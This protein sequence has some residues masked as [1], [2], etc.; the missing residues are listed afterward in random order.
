MA[1]KQEKPDPASQMEKHVRVTAKVND[2]DV[3]CFEACVPNGF[4]GEFRK[5]MKVFMAPD[6]VEIHVDKVKDAPKAGDQQQQADQPKADQS[7]KDDPLGE[8]LTRQEREGTK[9]APP[10]PHGLHGQRGGPHPA[11]D[12]SK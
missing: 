12:K 8:G 4:D 10:A 6:G 9:A 7:G 11:A 5:F 3:A 2:V 1:Q